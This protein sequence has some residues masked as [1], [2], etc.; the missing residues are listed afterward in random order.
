[1]LVLLLLTG[2]THVHSTTLL[3]HNGV[4]LLLLLLLWNAIDPLLDCSNLICIACIPVTFA[5]GDLLCEVIADLLAFMLCRLLV[6]QFL[7]VFC[8]FDAL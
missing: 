8:I 3:N 2:C 4:L 6:D 7:S 1:L 5:A